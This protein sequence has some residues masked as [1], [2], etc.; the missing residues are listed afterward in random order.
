MPKL[1]GKETPGKR[2]VLGFDGGCSAC[3]ELA[4]R[5][6]ERLA[7]KLEVLSLREPEV[8]EWRKKALGEDAPLVP[9]LFEIR[10]P[11]VRA[12]TRWRL[13]ARLGR[14]LGPVA[15]WRVVQALDEVGEV[16]KVEGTPAVG[17]FTGLTRG[18]FLKGVGGAAVAM[19]VLSTTGKLVSPAE[20]AQRR[21]GQTVRT[22][23]DV[24]GASIANPVEWSVEREQHTF[25]DTYGFTLW[26]PEPGSTEDHGGEPAVRVALAYGLRPNQIEQTVRAKL[27][28]YSHLPMT[29]ERVIVGERRLK[30]V[31]VGPI[32]GS[33]PSTEVYV[34][35]DG[36]VY[37]INVYGEKLDADGRRLLLGLRFDRP[38]RPVESLGLP[39][40]KAPEA[41]HQRGDAQLLEREQTAR[42]EALAEETAGAMALSVPVYN[43]Y[44]IY[45]GCWTATSTYFFQTQH[46]MYANK[47]WGPSYT[48]WTQIGIPNYWGQYTHG[49]LGYG[50]CVAKIYTNDMYA[51]D[52][53]LGKCD[54]IF[55]P[56][57]RGTVTFAGRN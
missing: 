8:E 22:R 29:R 1:T 2:L 21:T 37:Q 6:E 31:A 32:P 3:S 52:Y 51:V 25:D 17:A 34:A 39:D 57:K 9:T 30:G 10:G 44:R 47:R 49:S 42:R 26:K 18:Q 15:A 16:F 28:T 43:E 50:R 56:F 5:I 38:S 27:A 36:R 46:G 11:E 19:S 55:S 12:W 53:P 40:G 35:V 23:N 41:F 13:G 48:G 54:V 14:F 7:G 24:V 45:E 20:A 33:T 4:R